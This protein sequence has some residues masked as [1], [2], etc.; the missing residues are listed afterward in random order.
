M[1]A[2]QAAAGAICLHMHAVGTRAMQHAYDT[3]WLET[4]LARAWACRHGVTPVY[5]VPGVSVWA[6]QMNSH[7]LYML[8]WTLR[9]LSYDVQTCLSMSR[10]DMTCTTS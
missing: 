9:K 6:A 8:T 2:Y 5:L 1:P 4:E 3:V 10:S 7:P